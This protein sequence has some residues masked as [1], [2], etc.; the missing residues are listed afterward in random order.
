MES[1]IAKL[2]R[3]FL[4]LAD[5]G[6]YCTWTSPEI[7]ANRIVKLTPKT[8][9]LEL[10]KQQFKVD[11]L[12]FGS[13]GEIMLDEFIDY[14]TEHGDKDKKMRFEKETSFDTNKR[15]ARWHKRSN[16]STSKGVNQAWQ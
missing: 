6:S 7:I 8:K 12:K 16:K 3:K 5:D 14:W 1:E 13:Y 4:T 10:R 2:L 15:L 11:V 9:P